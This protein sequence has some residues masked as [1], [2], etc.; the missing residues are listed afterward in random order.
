VI[1]WELRFWVWNPN[2]LHR[3][4]K[5]IKKIIKLP[6]SLITNALKHFLIKHIHPNLRFFCCSYIYSMGQQFRR[7]NFPSFFGIFFNNS[8]LTLVEKSL[9]SDTP[10]LFFERISFLKMEIIIK[11]S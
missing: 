10:N 1:L 11:N 3:L 7:L 9:A 2:V 6:F 5:K 8:F 4:N